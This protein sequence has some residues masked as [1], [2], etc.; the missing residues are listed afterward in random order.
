MGLTASLTVALLIIAFLLG[1]ESTR[2]PV[3]EASVSAPPF[4]EPEPIVG[5]GE[6]RR[7][8][9]W[10][11]LEEWEDVKEPGFAAEPVGERIEQRPESTP[12]LANVGAAVEKPQAPRDAD[13]SAI[14]AYFLRMDGFH[15]Q[16]GA[17]D[18]NTFAMGLIKA[19]LGGSTAG[20]D[21]LIADTRRMEDQIRRVTPPPCCVDYH[22]ANLSALAES[23]KILDE[24]KRSFA[25]RDFSGLSAVAQKAGTLQAKAEAMQDMRAQ[26]MADAKR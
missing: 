16:S 14:S 2:S 21:Q 18:P 7:W 26:I 13:D 17:G 23:R 11:D 19:G 1:R 15:A 3:V 8:P 6:P 25:K 22:E 9:E 10:A 4:V 20:F 12:L 24:M 5:E